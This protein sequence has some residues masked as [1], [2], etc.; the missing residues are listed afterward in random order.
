MI[1]LQESPRAPLGSGTGSQLP[2]QQGNPGRLFGVFS[3]MEGTGTSPLFI[4]RYRE[5]RKRQE[6]VPAFPSPIVLLRRIRS[7]SGWTW[8]ELAT[9]LGV[10][11]RALHH[12]DAGGSLSRKHLER[13][14]RL[15]GVLRGLD[16]G[17]PLQMRNLLMMDLGGTNAL[18]LLGAERWSEVENHPAFR[19]IKVSM[20]LPLPAG[21]FRKRKEKGTA[22]ES[23]ETRTVEAQPDRPLPKVMIPKPRKGQESN[24]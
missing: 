4:S 1:Y 20:P 16:T 21:E 17:N 9:A 14:H 24:G 12:W 5:E 7:I 11:R 3:L 18:S 13:L 2:N 19:G 15:A 22:L 23:H 8:E 6:P 10:S